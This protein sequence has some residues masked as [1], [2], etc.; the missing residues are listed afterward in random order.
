MIKQ[1]FILVLVVALTHCKQGSDNGLTIEYKKTFDSIPSASGLAIREDSAY[2]VCDDGTGIYQIN[3]RNFHQNKIEIKGLPFNQYREPKPVKHDFESACFVKWQGKEYL[4]AMGS[5]SNSTWRDSLLIVNIPDYRDQ[6]I[7]SL[8][9]FYKQLQLK[10][11]TDTTQWNIEGLAVSGNNLIM[12]NRGNNLLISCDVG[13]FF[14]W[15]IKSNSVLPRIKYQ[16]IHLPSI[17]KHEARLS[18]ICNLDEQNLLVC[19]SVEDTPDWTKDGPVLG[20][21]FAVYSLKN[22]KITSTYLLQEE[23]GKALIEKIESVDV[24]QKSSN[25]DFTFLALGENDNG[26]SDLFKIILRR[27]VIDAWPE[28]QTIEAMQPLHH[29]LPNCLSA[30]SRYCC[31]SY[32][33]KS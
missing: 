19:A 12:A 30:K 24:L 25:G 33:V 15:L 13:D 4:M 17:D 1:M 29:H 18:G 31:Q 14:S 11:H 22:D 6:R 21:Y 28:Q 26:S 27:A 16:R 8:D 10:T 23:E 9:E 2:V 5:G 7:I 20:S 32:K 3:L